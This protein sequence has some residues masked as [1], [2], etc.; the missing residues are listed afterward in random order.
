[1][2]E[3]LPILHLDGE[4]VVVSKPAGM[5]VHRTSTG[6][7]E[8]ALLQCLRDQLGRPVFPVQ[9][10]DRWTSGAI[11]YGL[12]SRGAQRLQRA[13][14]SPAAVKEYLA[15]VRGLV[16]AP[17][18]SRT[19]LV[20][21]HAVARDAWSEFRPREAFPAHELS[22][23]VARLH[24]G[25]YHQV[26]RHLALAGHHVCGDPRYGKAR[27]NRHLAAHHG[28]ARP[29]LHAWRLAIPRAEDVALELEAPLTGELEHVL[30]SLR[31][32]VE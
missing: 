32:R 24:T 3:L 16:R 18:E 7:G 14:Q 29:F 10:L 15:L 25:R 2:A 1:V 17:F 9:R 20:D 13:L 12:S 27:L 19:P 28:L 23:I 22:L 8:E 11:A 5:L 4:L 30:E 21:D 31:S 6:S 26:R